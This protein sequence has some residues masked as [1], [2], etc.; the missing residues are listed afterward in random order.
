MESNFNLR[1]V[2]EAKVTSFV[3]A[4]QTISKTS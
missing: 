3:N 4:H 2:G 1:G